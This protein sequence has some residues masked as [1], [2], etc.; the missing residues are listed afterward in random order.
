MFQIYVAKIDPLYGL[1][2][3]G[4]RQGGYELIADCK[5]S[6]SYEEKYTRFHRL[7]LCPSGTCGMSD[8]LFGNT[9]PLVQG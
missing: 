3:F 2:I 1:N 5:K 9:D 6:V 7:N 4:L 8:R